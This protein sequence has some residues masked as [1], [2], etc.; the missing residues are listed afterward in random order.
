MR[1][2]W[3]IGSC[4][5]FISKRHLNGAIV[6]IFAVTQIQ[7][8]MQSYLEFVCNWRVKRRSWLLALLVSWL[9]SVVHLMSGINC[10]TIR[11]LLS[12]VHLISGCSN[13]V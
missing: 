9:L 10:G 2:Q 4:Q 1:F 3:L 6:E 7:E 8:W 12:V 13:K 5:V 11:W